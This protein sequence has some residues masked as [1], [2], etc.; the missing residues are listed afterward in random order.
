MAS[1]TI[2]NIPEELLAELRR[3]A[4]SERRS[5]NSEII[6][7]LERA[8]AGGDGERGAHLAAAIRD[9]LES[10]ERLCG[11]WEDARPVDEAIRDLQRSRTTGR[12][13]EL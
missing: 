9:Q 6:V 12:G 4:E 5:L 10:W 11:R 2:R 8:V 1:L 7:R 3:L 13:V